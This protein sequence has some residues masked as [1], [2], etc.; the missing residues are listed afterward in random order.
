MT[1]LLESFELGRPGRL[2]AKLQTVDWMIK[3]DF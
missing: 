1:G 3:N 2:K